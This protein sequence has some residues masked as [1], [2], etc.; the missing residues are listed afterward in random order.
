MESTLQLLTFS[1]AI[2]AGIVYLSKKLISAFV[3][4]GVEQYKAQLQLENQKQ[5]N[6][7]TLE[8]EKIRHEY[9]ML[10]QKN[11]ALHSQKTD[12]I[13]EFYAKLV[14][15]D[16]S[17][18][19]FVS[20]I[21]PTG[22]MT[23]VEFH[24]KEIEELNQTQKLQSDWYKY[25]LLNAIYFDDSTSE[26]ITQLNR[27]MIDA[28]FNKRFM[29]SHKISVKMYEDLD[30]KIDAAKSMAEELQKILQRSFKEELGVVSKNIAVPAQ[31]FA[32]K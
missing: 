21:K 1:A 9:E 24:E 17:L 32:F 18:R 30:K 26:L 22:S 31:A 7:F 15:F 5:Q 2:F 10:K 11:L 23:E 4:S 25:F 8:L 6:Q 14:E 16:L 13:K 27:H 19:W 20:S 12:V 3:E 29:V 28:L